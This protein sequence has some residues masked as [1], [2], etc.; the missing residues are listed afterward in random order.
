MY[1]SEKRSEI[2][3]RH[4]VATDIGGNFADPSSQRFNTTVAAASVHLTSE[5]LAVGLV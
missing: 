1:G 3:V 2:D 4:K 5:G